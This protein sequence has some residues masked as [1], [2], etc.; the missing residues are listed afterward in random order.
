MEHITVYEGKE[1]YLFLSYAHRDAAAVMEIAARLQDE[2]Y[3]I[4]YDAGIEVGSEWPEY[5]A[6]HLSGAGV[7]LAF[8]SN[9]YTASDNC[10]REMHFALSKKIPTV[11][12]FLEDTALS[13]GLEMQIGNL[14][15]LMK[16]ALP[17]EQFYHR[18]LT[19]PQLADLSH[20]AKGTVHTKKP[21]PGRPAAK[22]SRSRRIAA[23]IALLMLLAAVVTLGIVGHFTGLTQR[24][25][26]RREQT[27]LIALPGDTEAVFNDNCFERAA[28]E[29]TGQSEGTVCVSQLA[30]MT[31]LSLAGEISDLS[32][33]RYFTDC[34]RLEIRSDALSTLTTLPPCRLEILRLEACPLTSLKGIGALP[35]LRE[36]E[37]EACPLRDLG[38]LSR[39]LELRKLALTGADISSYAALRPLTKLAEARLANSAINELRPLLGLSSL[40]DLYLVNCDLRGR[41]F[42]SFDRESAIVS[43]SLIDCE[44]NSTRN[45]HDFTGM[46]TLTLVRSGARLDWSELAELPAL[47]TVSVDRSMESAIASVLDETETT[48]LVLPD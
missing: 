23:G 27:E 18:L 15:A 38:D 10:R 47:R 28:R 14:F 40:T 42:K 21:R 39:C 25:M 1:P 4:W 37:T 8:I 24:L 13:P 20:D 43:L 17:E 9:A 44:L 11:N 7:M 2:G 46:T 45:L 30:G 6:S 19:A 12:I 35:L 26:I 36:L 34:R 48:L 5:I 32:D 29:Y 41:F 16:Y 33:L 22:K 31:E 3:R